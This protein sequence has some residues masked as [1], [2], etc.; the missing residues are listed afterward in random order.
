MLLGSHHVD[1]SNSFDSVDDQVIT[2]TTMLDK[3]VIP[4]I[5][6]TH[7]TAI[8]RKLTPICPKTIK[9]R[10]MFNRTSI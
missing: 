4:K 6:A 10:P 2:L 5:I 8:I 3:R 9:A 7:T 1:M